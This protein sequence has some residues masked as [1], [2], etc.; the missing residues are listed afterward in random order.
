MRNIFL[1][2]RRYRTLFTFLIFQGVAL[3]F[4]FNYNRFHR[5][6]FL[7]FANEV[8]GKFNTQYNNVEDFFT[9]KA[10]NKRL[11]KV[12]DSL[13]NLLPLNFSKIDTS[14]LLVKD[15]IPFDTTGQVRQYL[16]RDAVV[17]YNT[18]NLE[19]NYIQLNRGSMQGIKKDMAVI[20]SGGTA[21]GII[22]NTSNNFSVVMPLLHVQ[23]RRSI[24]IKKTGTLGMVEWDGKNPEFLTVRNMPKSDSIVKG[25]T[26]I[27]SNVSE[28]PPGFMVGTVTEVIADK[29]TNFLSLKVKTAAN[30]YSLQQV[31]IVEKLF[32]AEQF[33]L[34][35]ETKQN[36]DNP[37]K[38]KR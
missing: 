15:S 31:H 23:S 3:W 19:K 26:V 8:T 9:L 5:A 14:T 11:N 7:G 32:A 33:A 24:I 16:W 37:K 34:L 21:V 6:K 10:E 27:T 38:A 35:T 12:N 4:L 20:G 30:F 28:F 18:V 25:D 22:I 2:I 36:I 29:S 1:F 13:F 17:V